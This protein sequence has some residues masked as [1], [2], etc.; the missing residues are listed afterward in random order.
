MIKLMHFVRSEKLMKDGGRSI[1]NQG[2]IK[3]QIQPDDEAGKAMAESGPVTAMH[4][5][6]LLKDPEAL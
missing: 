3:T 1:Y 2:K 5:A 6:E 4:T